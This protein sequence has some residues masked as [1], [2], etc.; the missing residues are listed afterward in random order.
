MNDQGLDATIQMPAQASSLAPMVDKLYYE[1]YWFSVI[2][3]VG[4]VGAMVYFAWRYR[5]RKGVV[6]KPPGHHN[7]LELF[8]TFS[9]LILLAYF[10][11]QGFT[12]FM[13]MSVP[14]PNSINVRV[15]AFQWGWRFQQPN[16]LV[17]SELWAPEHRP[18]R[19]IMSSVPR[20]TGPGQGAVLH[21]FFVPALR[22]KRDVVP[23]MYASVWFEG[24]RRGTYDI[25]CAEYCGVGAPAP[26]AV[27]TN[28]QLRQNGRPTAAAGHSGM[29]SRLHIVSS[30]EYQE[31][32]R[33]GL[34][35]PEKYEG[36]YAAWGRDLY[37]ENGCAACHVVEP[38]APATV[39]PNLSNVAG[40]PQALETGESVVADLEYLRESLRSPQ[41]QVVAGYGGASMPSFGALGELKIDAL[42]AYIASLSD[43]G[44]SVVD[45]VQALHAKPAEE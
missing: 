5:R 32:L 4:V 34:D 13:F 25:Y 18:V 3:F 29:I 24:T 16:G 44:Q 10:F 41:A 20:G 17:E 33:A 42:S 31:H 28:E 21:S 39:G 26:G 14:P 6:S 23:G 45:E 36:D 8:W 15:E 30:A 37:S 22:V 35:I 9:P 12:G 19:L 40:Y 7:A 1:V 27:L 11:H 43:Q 2:S 38:G